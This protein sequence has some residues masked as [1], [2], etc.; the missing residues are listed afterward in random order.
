MT[1]ETQSQTSPESKG[2][3]AGFFSIVGF[4]ALAVAFGYL[5]TSDTWAEWSVPVRLLVMAGF[6]AAWFGGLSLGV[7]IDQADQRSQNNANPPS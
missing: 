5:R 6:V 3:A 1:D 2:L 7:A 4:I